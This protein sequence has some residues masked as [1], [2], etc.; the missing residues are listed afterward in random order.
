MSDVCGYCLDKK[1]TIKRFFAV[2]DF[3]GIK[4]KDLVKLFGVSDVLVS[5]WRNGT[6]FPEWDKIVLFA[7][8]V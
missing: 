3:Y 1:A 5:Y 7:Y 8:M 2:C 4:N 6:R